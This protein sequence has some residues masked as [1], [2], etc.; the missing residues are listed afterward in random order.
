MSVGAFPD[1]AAG[2]AMRTFTGPSDWLRADAQHR[3]D[4]CALI[5]EASGRSL[6]FAE[7]DERVNRAANGLLGELGVRPGERVAVVAT[8]SHRYVEVILACFRTGITVIPLNVRLLPLELERFLLRGEA[9]ALFAGPRY[10]ATALELQRRVP[11]LRHVVSL[12]D[13]EVGPVPYESLLARSAPTDPG[14]AVDPEAVVCLAFTSGTTGMAKAVEQPLRMLTNAAMAGVIAYDVREGDV[15]YAAPPL[16]HV[17]GVSAMLRGLA[18]AH[19]SVLLP[20]FDAVEVLRWLQSDQLTG[21]ALVPTMLSSLLELPG[22]ADHDYPVLRSIQYGAA[23]ITPALLRRAMDVFRCDFVQMFGAGTEAGLQCSLSAADHRR[24]LA[25]DE[26]LLSSIGRPALGVELRIVDAELRDVPLGEVGE[27]ATRSDMVMKGYLDMPEE[28]AEALRGG[29]FRAGDLARMDAEGYVYLAGRSK[30]MIIRGGENLYPIEIE[31]VLTEH[32]DVVE[33]AVVGKPDAHWGEVVVAFVV[34]RDPD[35]TEEALRVHCRQGL[36]PH[37]VP[38]EVQFVEAMPK[39]ASGKVLKR[40]L[41]AM[42]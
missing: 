30:D 4:R 16:F 26:H 23:P 27:I 7:L 8:D 15:R 42:C 20:Q 3:G 31:A 11:T 14:L 1:T 29:W 36:A 38:A 24:A 9:R 33:A 39:N 32:P 10:V 19:T 22:V 35:L 2:A 25:G 18:V 17:S 34:R 21:V 37:K 6:S 40:D 28:T 13:A 5:D 12:G 41:R